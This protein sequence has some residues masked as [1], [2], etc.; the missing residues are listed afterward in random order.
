MTVHEALAFIK[1]NASDQEVVKFLGEQT[2]SPEKTTEIIEAF[3]KSNEFQKSLQAEGDRRAN[4][5]RDK[6]LKDEVPKLVEA[7]TKIQ[8][9]N[10]KDREIRELL[11]WKKKSEND[12]ERAKFEKQGFSI[13]AKKGYDLEESE[14]IL[15]NFNFIDVESIES[16]ATRFRERIDS[17]VL[18]ETTEKFK[19]A[20]SNPPNPIN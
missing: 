10:P 19:A 7:A 4:K 6:I 2:V 9:E 5:E 8:D 14:D 11:E 16:F 20:G 13:L 12:L 15:K 3:K 17:K 18:K 1:E